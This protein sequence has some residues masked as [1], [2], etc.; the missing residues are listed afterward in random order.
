[1]FHRFLLR[2]KNHSSISSIPISTCQLTTTIRL[3]LYFQSNAPFQ[4]EDLGNGYEKRET[5]IDQSQYITPKTANHKPYAFK[6]DFL[7]I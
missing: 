2:R 4:N 1:M 5:K 3:K 7:R 6:H